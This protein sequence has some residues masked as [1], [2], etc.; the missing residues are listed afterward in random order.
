MQ[1]TTPVL[2]DI[3]PSGRR[4]CARGRTAHVRMDPVPGVR[5]TLLTRQVH[6]PLRHAAGHGRRHLHVDEAH[7]DCAPLAAFA[8]ARIYHDEATG[9]DLA[10]KRIL[11]RGRPPVP[12]D[13]LS[14]DIGST[15]GMDGVPAR[16]PMR[17][18]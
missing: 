11:C 2:K 15:P 14:I 16:M 6:T 12:F 8:G 10:S 13:V 9:L 7:I 4:S 18:L 1:R 5:L 17:S 3:R